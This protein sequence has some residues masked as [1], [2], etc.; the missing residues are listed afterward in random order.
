MSAPD[1]DGGTFFKNTMMLGSGQLAMAWVIAGRVAAFVNRSTGLHDTA[2]GEAIVR[3]AGGRVTTFDGEDIDYASGSI[4]T[5]V[6]A[7]L[8][9]RVHDRLLRLLEQA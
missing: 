3:A 7:T 8:D 6:V 1:D 4:R 5:S 2:A 9:E